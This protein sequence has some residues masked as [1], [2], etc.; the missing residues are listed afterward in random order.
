M[1]TKE[2]SKSR[3]RPRSFDVDKAVAQ[4]QAL[5]HEQGYDGVG[6]AALT[7]ALGIAPP[8]F[9]AAFGSKAGLFDQVLARYAACALPMDDLLKEGRPPAGA[10]SELLETAARIYVA[11]P[12]ASGCLVLESARAGN[13]PESIERARVFKEAS[14]TR[15]A[16]FVALTHPDRA[17]QVGD[18]MVTLMSGLSAGAREGWS[19]ARLLDVARI[20]ILPVR[21]M[22]ET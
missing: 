5:F 21:A 9:Y 17:E 8:S 11:D 10:L 19:E 14:R 2:K 6:V 1:I 7:Q 20:A 22:L 18:Y 16:S 13:D 15:I 4:A 3:G 12:R